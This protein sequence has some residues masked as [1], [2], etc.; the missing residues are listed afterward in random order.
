M[1]TAVMSHAEVLAEIDLAHVRVL[2]DLGAC[3][4]PARRLR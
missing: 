4:R 1:D 3:L 2:D